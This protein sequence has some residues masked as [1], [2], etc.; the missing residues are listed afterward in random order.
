MIASKIYE[1]K[2]K[3]VKNVISLDMFGYDRGCVF[4]FTDGSRITIEPD[5]CLDEPRIKAT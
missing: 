4:E 1:I 3:T 2:N 5:K